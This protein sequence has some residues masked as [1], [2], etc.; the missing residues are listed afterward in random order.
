MENHQLQEEKNKHL[1]RQAK[2]RVGFRNHFIMYLACNAFFWALW[3]FTG[4]KDGDDGIPWPILPGLGWGFGLFFHFLSV[5]VFGN[6]LS[7][8]EKEYERLKKKQG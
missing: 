2:K 1:W 3:Y 6:K 8:I 5:Y 7:S 4:R